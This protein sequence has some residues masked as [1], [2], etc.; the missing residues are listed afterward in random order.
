MVYY[1][2]LFFS[3][4]IAAWMVLRGRAIPI[5]IFDDDTSII[6][7]ETE[8]SKVTYLS[9]KSF[10]VSEEVYNTLLTKIILWVCSHNRFFWTS[11][12]LGSQIKAVAEEYFEEHKN[13]D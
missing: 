12:Q 6:V 11:D 3:R 13:R 7:I 9:C 5:P 2:K 8:G 10:V 4:L 1:C